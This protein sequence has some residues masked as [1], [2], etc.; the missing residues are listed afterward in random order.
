[1]YV[2]TLN[3]SLTSY[4]LYPAL[5]R[6]PKSRDIIAELSYDTKK[7][8]VELPA[9]EATLDCEAHHKS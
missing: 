5:V 2:V 1:M 3:V 6:P 7:N 4:V 9:R 8:S